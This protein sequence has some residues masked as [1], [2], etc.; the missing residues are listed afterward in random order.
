M[1]HPLV[2]DAD[3]PLGHHLV[4]HG[5]LGEDRKAK[6]VEQLGDGMVY[7]AVVV[8]GTSRQHDA[9][10][11]RVLYP[12]EGLITL[13]VHGL[14]EGKVLLPGRVHGRVYL[15]ARDGR[16]TH[17]PLAGR[18]VLDT[19]DGDDL[20]EAALELLL[21][22][23]GDEGVQ[24][25]DIYVVLLFDQINATLSFGKHLLSDGRGHF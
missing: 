24:V 21:V 2:H 18:G 23:V 14:L 10:R 5:V 1:V 12:L 13:A 4:G 3:G 20:K 9:V 8:V 15:F 11:T 19:L 17:T 6:A 7:L 25:L 16:P 22:V